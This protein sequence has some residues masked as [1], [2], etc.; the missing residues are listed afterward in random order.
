M[1]DRS[2]FPW[3]HLA[4]EIILVCV[5]RSVRY[6]LSDRAIEELMCERGVTVDQTTRCR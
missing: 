4:G 2:L 3:C 5:R 1:S 6:A